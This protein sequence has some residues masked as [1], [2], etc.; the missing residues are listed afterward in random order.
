MRLVF[1]RNV[2]K[3]VVLD[4]FVYIGNLAFELGFYG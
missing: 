4:C 1:R 3:V 2:I